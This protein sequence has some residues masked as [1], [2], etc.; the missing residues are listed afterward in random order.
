MLTFISILTYI[1]SI[2]GCKYVFLLHSSKGWDHF[3]DRD[4][5]VNLLWFMP[6]INSFT[7][8]L[9]FVVGYI[10]FKKRNNKKISKFINWL[11]NY[12][13]LEKPF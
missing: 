8:I 6:I 4:C 12:D 10:N 1:L 5:T 2:I 9:L 3:K 11:C 7:V 13:L